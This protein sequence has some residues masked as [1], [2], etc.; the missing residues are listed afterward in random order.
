MQIGFGAP[1]SG[2]W[3]TPDNLAALRG[4]RGKGGL[5]V[6]VVL[7]AADRA[8]GLRHGPGVPGV[9]DP[10]AALAYAAAVTRTIRLG[11]AI[12]NL[13]FVSPG[14]LAKQ[15]ASLD[16]LSA[17]RHDLGLGI[18]W[19]P[20]EFTLTGADMARR[21][22]RTAEYIEVLR[23]LWDDE[24][25]EFSGE[26][27]T[28]PRGSVQP[29]PVQRRRPA[30]PARRHGQARPGAGRAPGRRLGDLQPH[31]PVPDRRGHRRGEGGRRAGRPRPGEAPVHLPRRGPGRAPRSPARTASAC[32]CPAATSRSATTPP[33]SASR[34]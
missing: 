26:F 32:C 5:R 11:V 19:M 30:D 16:V 7:P 3:A 12:V 23:T 28:V 25:S 33:G 15:A 8:R 22:A 27:Y 10:Y 34:A 24:I 13:P 2:A 21:G 17:G 14:Y 20:E 29:K 6:A 9:L 1:V 4:P 31:R 18:G